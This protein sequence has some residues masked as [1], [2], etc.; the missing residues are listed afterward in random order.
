MRIFGSALFLC[1]ILVCAAE[2]KTNIFYDV[3]DFGAVGDGTTL[4]TAAIQK[5]I[6][7]AHAEG[8]GQV[9]VPRGTFLAGSLFLK[10]HVTLYLAP[11]AVLL[12]SSRPED[13]AP[14][15]F[16]PQNRAFAGDFVKGSHFIIA[17]EQENVKIC[18][19]G[20]INGNGITFLK[21]PNS[22]RLLPKQKVPW[23]PGQ[24][25]FFCECENVAVEGVTLTNSPY[26][27][28][29]YHGCEN[30]R[31]EGVRIRNRRDAANADG[32]DIDCCRNVVIANCDI[33]TCDDC[34]TLRASTEPLKKKRPCEN[35]AV[36]NCVLSSACQAIRVGVGDGEIR[37]AVFSNLV[38][39][40]TNVGLNFHS[41]YSPKSPGTTIRNIR[42]QN[43]VMD[44]GE[45]FH[46]TYGHAAADRLIS[47]VYFSD[48]SGTAQRTSYLRGKPEQPLKNIHFT[49]IDIHCT[50]TLLKAEHVQG[51]KTRDCSFSIPT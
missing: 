7:T 13:Y 24:M 14:V 49:D 43:I 31:I 38:I 45:A 27:T 44:V 12:A 32:I 6:D 10:S 4:N 33:D 22:N 28:S 20:T 3:T 46:M 50:D 11:N 17:V 21:D 34:I 2:G 39:H 18:G 47:D 15:D 35:V 8:G 25:L 36:T 9:V 42:F 5:A 19:E 30:V 16:C 1:G 23:R 26:W 51:G 48:I 41:S 37:N 29:F 40:N